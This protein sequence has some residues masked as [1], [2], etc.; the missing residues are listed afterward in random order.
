MVVSWK[1]SR[2]VIPLARDADAASDLSVM[3]R[4][5]CVAEG[6]CR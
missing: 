1:E 6:K 3:R 5:I 2:H 4:D